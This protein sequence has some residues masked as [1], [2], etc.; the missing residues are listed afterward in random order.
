MITREKL[1]L[2]GA[3]L[4]GLS[5]CHLIFPFE[6]AQGADAWDGGAVDAPMVDLPRMDSTRGDGSADRRSL[7]DGELLCGPGEVFCD[8]CCDLQ[9]N[10]CEPAPHFCVPRAC[11]DPAL[12][13][14]LTLDNLLEDVT[15]G[16]KPLQTPISVSFS[17]DG[18]PPGSL[19][20]AEIDTALVYAPTNFDP[21]AGTV[22]L[23]LNPNLW[24][25][26][27]TQSW[28]LFSVRFGLNDHITI[29]NGK[30]KLMG[31]AEVDA[32]G[33]RVVG[34][35]SLTAFCSA[36]FPLVARPQ[37]GGWHQL[38][39]VYDGPAHQSVVFFD[40][41]PSLPAQ[42]T[43]EPNPSYSKPPAEVWVGG[44]FLPGFSFNG[45]LDEVMVFQRPLLPKEL[46]ALRLRPCPG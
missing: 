44:S 15:D 43:C 14:H 37:G 46:E 2:L 26:K 29:G 22:V 23:W 12:L 38:A 11:S 25:L 34:S 21:G 30:L 42:P 18:K 20:R 10:T 40:G 4:L 31:G 5:G 41:V 33:A 39:W 19:K 8:G 32:L 16:D 9:W 35:T 36:Y 6:Q 27:L 3:L 24:A 13:M 7:A 1:A 17:A 45:L 28:S